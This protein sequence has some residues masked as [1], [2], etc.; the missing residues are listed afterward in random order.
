ME[1]YWN[2]EDKLECKVHVKEN[3]ALKYLNLGSCHT[4]NCFTAIP[5]G[6]FNRLTKLTSKTSVNL[7]SRINDLCP[8]HTKA[9]TN[10]KL[11]PEIFPTMNQVLKEMNDIEKKKKRIEK[12]EKRKNSRAIYFCIGLSGVF[13]GKNAIHTIIKNLRNQFNL[14]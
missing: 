4:H 10:A 7:D 6:V 1:I 5:N 8:R 12:A 3:Q 13:T 9:L 11:A 14:K 2:D